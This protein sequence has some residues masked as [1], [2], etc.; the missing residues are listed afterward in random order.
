MCYQNNETCLLRIFSLIT[1][2]L[3]NVKIVNR[4]EVE[5]KLRFVAYPHFLRL[6]CS[7]QS[8]VQCHMTY[9]IRRYRSHV[10]Q[11]HTYTSPNHS[12]I[13]RGKFAH[14]RVGWVHSLLYKCRLRRH[15]PHFF[16]TSRLVSDRTTIPVVGSCKEIECWMRRWETLGIT[17]LR[18]SAFSFFLLA[19]FR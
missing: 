16:I 17:V 11:F 4:K 1:E 18:Y 7:L 19:I 8:T 2:K 10:C 14:R 15:T 13:S 3:E 6:Q 9:Q 5:V 12:C